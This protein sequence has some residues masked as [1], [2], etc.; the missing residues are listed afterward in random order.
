MDKATYEIEI[1]KIELQPK[2]IESIIDM[3]DEGEYEKIITHMKK[4][5]PKKATEEKTKEK[6]CNCGY[7][8][9]FAIISST[10][11]YEYGSTLTARME[12]EDGRGKHFGSITL[13]ACPKCGNIFTDLRGL[14]DL[15]DSD[16]F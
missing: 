6:I 7:H 2:T 9:N 1:A 12:S 15:G 5:T 3:Y 4:I 14:V 13:F 10:T 11:S 16:R 8:G